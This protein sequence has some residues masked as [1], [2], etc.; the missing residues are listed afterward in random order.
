MDTTLEPL[1]YA[2]AR[3]VGGGWPALEAAGR[4]FN[5]QAFKDAY[6]RPVLLFRNEYALQAVVA[7]HGG[8]LGEL[9]PVAAPPDA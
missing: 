3:W 2:A 8:K 5:A 1:P 9:A 6:G 4:L 7:E